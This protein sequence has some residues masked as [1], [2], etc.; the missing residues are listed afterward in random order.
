MRDT[1]F[2]ECA[3]GCAWEPRSMRCGMMSHQLSVSISFHISSVISHG[4]LAM[5]GIIFAWHA[6]GYLDLQ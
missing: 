6:S 3:W 4:F 5:G 2:H 1:C